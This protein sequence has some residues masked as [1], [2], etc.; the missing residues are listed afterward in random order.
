MPTMAPRIMRM[1]INREIVQQ[2]HLQQKLLDLRRGGGDGI[3]G[4]VC[5]N[6]GGGGPGGGCARGGAGFMSL[7]CNNDPPLSEAFDEELATRGAVGGASIS[8]TG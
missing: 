6:C 5:L 3:K 1:R 2:M 7:T 4:V 8:T